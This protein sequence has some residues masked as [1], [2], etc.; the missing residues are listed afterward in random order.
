[1]SAIRKHEDDTEANAFTDEHTFLVWGARAA[2]LSVDI[3]ESPGPTSLPCRRL[4]G[5]GM[6]Y[7]QKKARIPFQAEAP[8]PQPRF[9]QPPAA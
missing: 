9:T 6:A 5:E 4:F 1:M 8:P 2:A 3:S 7:Q